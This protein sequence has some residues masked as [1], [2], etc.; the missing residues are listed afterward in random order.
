[1]VTRA[2]A[3][4]SGAKTARKPTTRK[5]ATRKRATVA[6]RTTT[7][8]AT[9]LATTRKTARKATTAK[10]TT[11]RK[12]ATRRTAKR[13]TARKTPTKMRRV[14]V[15]KRVANKKKVG[16]ISHYFDRIGVAVVETKSAIQKGDRVSI[17][18]PMTNF[19]QKAR[20]MQ[21]NHK[22][23]EKATRGRSVGLKVNHPVRKKDIIYRIG[24]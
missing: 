24:E 3:S 21:H 22:Q 14:Q 13:T 12:T 5:V 10:R 7:R 4:R 19:K 18:G 16:I 17:E 1:M 23:I 6:R 8:T 9:R 2:T 11:A 20:S 15:A